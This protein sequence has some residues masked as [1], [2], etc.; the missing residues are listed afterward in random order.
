VLLE[1]VSALRARPALVGL[2]LRPSSRAF[3]GAVLSVFFSSSRVARAFSRAWAP[4]VGVPCAVRRSLVVGVPAWAVSV[5]VSVSCGWRFA[6]CFG[7]L[8]PASL[9]RL[10]SFF[11]VRRPLP[12]G[13][14]V[15][16]SAE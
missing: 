6:A 7:G 16:V 5:P 4:R 11:R 10:V 3:S 1:L 15:P 14:A 8:D 2:E 13:F 9:W 12:A